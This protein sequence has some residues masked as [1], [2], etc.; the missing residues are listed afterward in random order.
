MPPKKIIPYEANLAYKMG[1][2]TDFVLQVRNQSEGSPA[3]S[4]S[5]RQTSENNAYSHERDPRGHTR[6]QVCVLTFIPQA[7]WL[8]IIAITVQARSKA[9]ILGAVHF[10]IALDFI[11]S[12]SVVGAVRGPDD[13]CQYG[14]SHGQSHN[15][16]N[17]S[18][19][20]WASRSRIFFDNN[21]H[22]AK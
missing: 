1:L 21:L 3:W 2:F 6:K 11:F 7:T 14:Q 22:T 13:K 16:S 19:Y 9:A 5:Q 8:E 12:T 18:T 15:D 10:G 20:H 17:I 4:C